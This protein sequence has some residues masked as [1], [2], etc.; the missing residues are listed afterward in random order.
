MLQE[1]LTG[2]QSV[3]VQLNI[4]VSMHNDTPILQVQMSVGIIIVI[5][6]VLYMKRGS[7]NL[8]LWMQL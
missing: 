1:L 3:N 8:C 5:V 4:H 7:H 2:L 6:A